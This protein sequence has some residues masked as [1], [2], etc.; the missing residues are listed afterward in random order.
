MRYYFY[1]PFNFEVFVVKRLPFLKRLKN[2]FLAKG[3]H[4]KDFEL[5]ET[6]LAKTTKE[7]ERDTKKCF[8]KVL[9]LT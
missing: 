6:Q 2:V 8:F 1:Q 3:S 7:H 4:G 5:D 9:M